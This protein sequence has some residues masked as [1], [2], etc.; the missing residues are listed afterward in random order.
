MGNLRRRK[1]S[2]PGGNVVAGSRGRSV[3]TVKLK[4]ASSRDQ[5]PGAATVRGRR[6][7]ERDS[8]CFARRVIADDARLHVLE[9][10]AHKASRRERHILNRRLRV[11]GMISFHCGGAGDSGSRRTP[12]VRRLPVRPEQ[13]PPAIRTRRN[14]G[15][16]TTATGRTGPGRVVAQEDFGLPAR[17]ESHVDQQPA[18]VFVRQPRR[19]PIGGRV[20]IAED[21]AV[22]ARTRAQSVIV[23]ARPLG[24]EPA[25]IEA[26]VVLLQREEN[27]SGRAAARRRAACGS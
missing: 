10:A 23:D 2:A 5:R 14:S 1:T 17:A 19:N 21:L 15:S 3:G 16:R 25:V 4:N 8:S 7:P 27:C 24:I 18:A 13:A 9:I 20:A 6:G 26:R 22:L 11:P 12:A